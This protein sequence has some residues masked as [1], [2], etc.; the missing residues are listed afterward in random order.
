MRTLLLPLVFSLLTAYTMV[1]AQTSPPPDTTV[2]DETAD[3]SAPP[4][5]GGPLQV[6]PDGRF[7]QHAR[8]GKHF[9]YLADTPWSIFERL[10]REDAESYLRDAA[11]SGFTVIQ[12]VAL[13]D[14]SRSGNA[15]GDS[16]IGQT[17]GRYNP[18][19]I[20]VTPGNDPRDAAAYDYW[21]HVDFVVDKAEE[22]GLY[23]ALLPTWG[24]YVSGT[25]SYAFNMSSNIFT[26]ASA[27]RYGEFL[28]KRYGHRPNIIW[29]IGGDR[30]AVYPNGDF[31]H[32]WRALAEGVGRGVTGEPLEWNEAHPGWDKLLMTY[33]PRRA[34]DPGSSIWFH[35]DPWLDFNGIETEHDD[36]ARKVQADWELAPA[37]PT[38]L[39]EGRY[40]DEPDRRGDVAE[41]AF[42]HRYQLYHAV[43]SGS[44][45]YAYGHQRIW[46][47]SGGEDS[48]RTALR[49]PGRASMSTIRSLIDGLPNTKLLDRMP[50]NTLLDGDTGSSQR[51]SLLLAMRGGD[52]TFALVYSTNGRAIRLNLARLAT[53]TA[54]AF[55]FSPRTGEFHNGAGEVVSG[56][57][58]Q[59]STGIGSAVE[60]FD[61]PG[62]PGAD[63]DWV[64]KLAVRG[65]STDEIVLHATSATIAGDQ[66][67]LVDDPTAANG[68]RLQESN[69]GTEKRVVAVAD[70]PSFAEFTFS[71]QAGTGYR[72][73]IRGKGPNYASDS[74]FVQFSGSVDA[75]GEPAFRIGSTDATMYSVVG[76]DT[77]GRSGWGWQDNGWNGFGPLI[78]F[79][80]SGPQ[81]LRLQRRQDGIAIDQI[82][83]SPEKYLTSPPGTA[84][85]DRTILPATQQ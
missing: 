51:Q 41:G 66:W 1:Q 78:Y 75:N 13:W 7:L 38:A 14:L 46:R 55:W 72:L 47:M 26:A 40:E 83:L 2:P 52:G 70:P 34:D 17:K 6:A 28:G 53:G 37:K 36:V 56:A 25:T 68:V 32:V 33:H 22:N 5:A 61:P 74:V 77:C 85:Q 73:W 15:Y 63:N 64:L 20:I 71:A 80:E 76:C 29:V 58:R 4:W 16:P 9:F 3:A 50:D 48:W 62:A 67:M 11:A 65:T 8:S 10:D 45:G 44:I 30:S 79:A 59:V 31:R 42:M 69:D 82:V 12:A 19:D 57:F 35:D 23:V 84:L 27:R 54:D 81:T 39:L 18:S 60:V 49:D 43:F 21:D 24:N